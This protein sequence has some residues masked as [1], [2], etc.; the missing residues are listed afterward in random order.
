[1]ASLEKLPEG[2]WDALR[3]VDMDEWLWLDMDSP[4]LHIANVLPATPP[5]QVSHVWGWSSNAL[6]RARV[7][8]DI[9]GR[10]VGAVLHLADGGTGEQVDVSTARSQRWAE[11]DGR[12]RVSYPPGLKDRSRGVTLHRVSR[13]AVTARGAISLMPLDF[14]RLADE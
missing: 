13:M 11:A 1:M 8:R 10:V 5:P 9:P 6:V 7:D 2:G 14:V 4:G 12:V 3:S